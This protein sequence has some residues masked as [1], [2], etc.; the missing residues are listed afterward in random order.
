M[1][2]RQ[3]S[4]GAFWLVDAKVDLD[5]LGTSGPVKRAIKRAVDG[6]GTATC[7]GGAVKLTVTREAAEAAKEA[8]K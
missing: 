8:S 3:Q 2:V 6:D 7:L 1:I 5:K 4:T